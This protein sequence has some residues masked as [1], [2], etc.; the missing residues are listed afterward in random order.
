[1]YACGATPAAALPGLAAKPNPTFRTYSRHVGIKAIRDYLITYRPK[2]NYNAEGARGGGRC[3]A[4]RRGVRESSHRGRKKAG[5]GGP[6][7][8]GHSMRGISDDAGP[9]RITH[10]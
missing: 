3:A 6:R 5:R 10:A 1:M 2:I 8:G 9:K 7:D 4:V